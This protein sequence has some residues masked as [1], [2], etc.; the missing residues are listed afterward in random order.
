M[1]RRTLTRECVEDLHTGLYESHDGLP[2]ERLERLLP[3]GEAAEPDADTL[4]A[5]LNQ[6][7]ALQKLFDLIVSKA[8]CSAA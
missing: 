5:M 3:A 4:L 8:H 1:S 7:V 6:G 2:Y